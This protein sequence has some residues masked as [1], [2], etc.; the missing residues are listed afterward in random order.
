MKVDQT[1]LEIPSSLIQTRMDDLGDFGRMK[2]PEGANEYAVSTRRA[3]NEV[4][5]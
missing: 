4:L 3:E 1:S 5:M 2:L